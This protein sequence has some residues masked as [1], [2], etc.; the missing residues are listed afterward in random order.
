MVG[1]KFGL[2]G[3]MRVC[4]LMIA[5]S[6]AAVV[7][8]CNTTASGVEVFTGTVPRAI[9]AKEFR[10]TYAEAQCKKVKKQVL[11]TIY[12]RQKSDDTH[13]VVMCK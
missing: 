8:G 12:T 6:G 11:D 13:V 10:S 2:G 4:V 9:S 7:S 5:L 3:D 1:T